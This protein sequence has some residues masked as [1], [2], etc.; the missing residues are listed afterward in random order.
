MAIIGPSGS[1]KS[2]LLSLIGL[3]DEAYKGSISIDGVRTDSLSQT[4]QAAFVI[5]RLALFFSHLNSLLRLPSR[6]IL[7][8]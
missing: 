4:E 1:G 5:V 7:P 2:T 8:Y 6:K 3:L